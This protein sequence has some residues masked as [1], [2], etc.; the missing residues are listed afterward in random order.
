MA[1]CTIYKQTHN[2]I[3][4]ISVNLRTKAGGIP[5]CVNDGETQPRCIKSTMSDSASGVLLL[6]IL[7]LSDPSI[8]IS[9]SEINFPWHL[10]SFYWFSVHCQ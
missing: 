3:H 8:C 6:V 9:D 4:V 2:K 10:R 5:Y 7:M 1:M